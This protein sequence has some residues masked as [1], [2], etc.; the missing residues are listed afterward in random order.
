MKKRRLISFL[1]ALV[2]CLSLCACGGSE[3]REETGGEEGGGAVLISDA[4]DPAD[5][6]PERSVKTFQDIASFFGRR[7]D[8]WQETYRKVNLSADDRSAVLEYI[9]LLINEF[10]YEIVGTSQFD[11]SADDPFCGY[12]TNGVWEVCLGLTTVD[13]GRELRGQKI[14]EPCDIDLYYRRGA[15]EVRFSDLFHTEDYGFRWSGS[16][17]DR[18]NE[19]YGQRA[20]DAYYLEN[21]RYRNGSDGVLSVEAGTHGEAMILINGKEVLYSTSSVLYAENYENYT[22]VNWPSDDYEISIL[23][24]MKGVEGEYI[25]ITV[26]KTLMGGEV[27]TLSDG[28]AWLGDSPF[29]VAAA[30]DETGYALSYGIPK[31]RNATNACT[32]RVLRWDE[33]ECVVYLSMDLIYELEPMIVEALVAVPAYGSLQEDTFKEEEA[34]TLKAGETYDLKYIGPY[35]FMPNYETYEWK[36]VSGQGAAITG[37]GDT[38]TVTAVSPGQIIIKCVYSY[39]EDEPDVLTGIMRNENHTRSKLYYINIE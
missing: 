29:S 23:E 39:G 35:V 14:T 26:P 32:L 13:T 19:V 30:F 1:L 11:Y 36:L 27:Y 31:P 3:G 33:E 21:G 4:L 37:Y 12:F 38:C 15:L 17:G 18:F 16:Q 24:F 22:S 20:L 5:C 10:G 2:M 25:T 6:E 34:I 7:I 9:D 8:E 28:L